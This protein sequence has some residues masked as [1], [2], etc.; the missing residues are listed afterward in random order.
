MN[1]LLGLGRECVVDLLPCH[2]FGGSAV[3][4]QVVV[5]K[6]MLRQI[7]PFW[8]GAADEGS[9]MQRWEKRLRLGE[10]QTIQRTWLTT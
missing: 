10:V 5:A 3:E 7:W 6:V 4:K 2:V 9:H 8:S 1:R